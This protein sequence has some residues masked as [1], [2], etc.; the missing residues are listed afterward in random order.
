MGLIS[1]TAVQNGTAPDASQVNNPLN[2]IYDEFNGNITSANLASNAVTTNKVQDSAI[3]GAKINDG[4]VTFAKTDGTL[5]W[6]EIGR[7]TLGSASNTLTSPSL[8]PYKYISVIV[9]IIPSG[10]A[11]TGTLRFNGDTGNNY[12]ARTSTNGGADSAP[13][14]ATS[15]SSDPGSINADWF[16]EFRVLNITSREKIVF[17]NT[18]SA[19]ASG[20]GTAPTR[21]EVTGKWANTTNAISTLTF[22]TGSN[23]FA[24]GSEVVVYGRN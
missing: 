12:S 13:T 5:G 4:A 23:N 15:I 6:Q 18:V 21:R 9:H 19:A 11:V 17:G 22:T 24:I 16:G 10:G 14:S 3:T 20:A 8:P 7:T 2:T 1:F